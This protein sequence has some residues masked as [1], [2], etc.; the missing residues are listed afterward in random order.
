MFTPAFG[1]SSISSPEISVELE[2]VKDGTHL[3]SRYSAKSGS[4]GSVVFGRGSSMFDADF[5]RWIVHTIHG[6]KNF[7]GGGTLGSRGISA[8]FGTQVISPRK[9]LLIVQFARINLAAT[10]DVNTN[11]SAEISGNGKITAGVSAV[12]SGLVGVGLGP[13][14]FASRLPA[15]AWLLHDCLPVRYKSASDFDATSGDISMQELEVQPEYIEEFSL[16]GKV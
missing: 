16:G 8:I 12:L 4:V 13:F 3:F 1:F 9:N 15:R 14:Q 10:A 2:S 11:L 6:N 7:E 5:Y